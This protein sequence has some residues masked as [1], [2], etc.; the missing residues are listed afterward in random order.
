[1]YIPVEG[2]AL[3]YRKRR[4]LLL[5]K[6]H[7][8]IISVVLAVLIAVIVIASVSSA[9][10]ERASKEQAV[11]NQLHEGL[12]RVGLRG[13]IGSFCTLNPDTGQYEGLEKDV[14]DELIAR[15]LGEN[16]LVEYVD[17]NS[18]TKDAL[19]KK[20]DVDVSLGASINTD[21][22]CIFYTSPYFADACA[23]LLMEGGVTSQAGLSG[24]V[25]AVVQNSL[26]VQDSTKNEDKTMLDDYLAAQ[27]ISATVKEFASYPEAVD[28]LS[29]GVVEAVCASENDL[30]LFGKAGM[31]MLAERFLPNR[32]CLQFASVDEGLCGAFSDAINAMIEDGTMAG[33]ITKWN[34][35]DYSALQDV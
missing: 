29:S 4:L 13:D 18:R 30:K 17:V 8:V 24:G 23:F 11:A 21:Q 33:L 5:K 31:L 9:A 16:I 27:D 19:L 12:L 28:A 14:I 10:R 20:G 34:L 2:N 35:V 25:I 22:T 6:K 7:I 3:R 1:L 15:V 32:Y 26:P